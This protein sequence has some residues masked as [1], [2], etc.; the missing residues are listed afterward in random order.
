MPVQF[1]EWDNSVLSHRAAASLGRREVQVWSATQPRDETELIEL[2]RN[3]SPDEHGRAERFL[4]DEPRRRFVFGLSVMRQL[5]GACL[6]TVPSAVVFGYGPRGKPFLNPPI[7]GGDLRFNLS[8]SGQLVVIALA[9]GRE[10]GV[11]LEQIDRLADWSLLA[12]RIFS[13]REL[14]ELRAL[15]ASKQREAFFN[16]WTR[17]EAY[18]KATR[19]GLTDDLPAIEVTLVPGQKPRLLRLPAGPEAAR[20]WAIQDIPLPPDFAGA[21]AFE[22]RTASGAWAR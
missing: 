7:S 12:E 6:N 9:H 19:E 15:P 10:I 16:G 14:C 5:L 18:L 2:A 21:V 4:A 20:Q 17:K 8:H 1:R 3:L 11:D 22:K 13:S